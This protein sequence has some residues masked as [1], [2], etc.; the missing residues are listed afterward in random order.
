MKVPI[1]KKLKEILQDPVARK[2][3]Q[4]SLVGEGDGT[5]AVNGKFYTLDKNAFY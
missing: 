3:L 2:Q 5:I 1:N 4:K